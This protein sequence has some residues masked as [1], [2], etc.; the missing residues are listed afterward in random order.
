KSNVAQFVYTMHRVGK[1]VPPK[2][3]RDT[4]LR[5]PR[6]PASDHQ[7]NGF[8]WKAQPDLPTAS[9][10]HHNNQQDNRE[11]ANQKDIA[12]LCHFFGTTK[13]IR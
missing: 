6:H 10:N 5:A 2:P 7:R 13:T 3:Q 1:V 8:L 12:F 4:P 9:E 11:N